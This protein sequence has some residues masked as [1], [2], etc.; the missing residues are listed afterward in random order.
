MSSQIIEELQGFFQYES[1]MIWK[2]GMTNF[3]FLL[4]ARNWD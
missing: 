1:S 2:T 3:C 4:D